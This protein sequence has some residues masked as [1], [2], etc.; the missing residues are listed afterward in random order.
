MGIVKCC[1]S[2][3][4]LDV[5]SICDQVLMLCCGD[6]IVQSCGLPCPVLPRG[7]EEKKLPAHSV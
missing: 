7:M 2:V 1:S 4:I 3:M 5:R 6:Y